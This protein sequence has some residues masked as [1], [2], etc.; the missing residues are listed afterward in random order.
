MATP[1]QFGTGNNEY[2]HPPDGGITTT[3]EIV[4]E[5]VD[6]RHATTVGFQLLTTD[7]NGETSDTNEGGAA[8]GIEGT[9]KIE[10]SN[11]VGFA[12]PETTAQYNDLGRWTDITALISPTIPAAAGSGQNQ[13]VTLAD[14]AFRHVRVSFQ[15][16]AGTDDGQFAFAFGV[17][18]SR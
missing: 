8:G 14:F 15:P 9:W 11:S 6:S 18:K 4:G 17:G 5:H 3:D 7:G 13:V 1:L 12:P 2:L 16:T 10:V